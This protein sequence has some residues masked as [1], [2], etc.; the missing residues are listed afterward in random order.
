MV[1]LNFTDQG[2][3]PHAHPRRVHEL[4]RVLGV[5]VEMPDEQML[6][7][8]Y[9]YLGNWEFD[10]IAAELGVEESQ[11]A[12]LAFDGLRALKDADIF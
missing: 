2:T 11:A 3:F 4:N 8:G 6:A 5:L 1:I 7:A 9:R 12:R 10:K